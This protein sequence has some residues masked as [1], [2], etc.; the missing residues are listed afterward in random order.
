MREKIKVDQLLD[1]TFFDTS[2]KSW[3]QENM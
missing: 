3:Q 2:W 1:W